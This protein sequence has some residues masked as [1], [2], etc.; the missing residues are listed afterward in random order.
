MFFD[1]YEIH[2]QAFVNLINAIGI[3]FDPHLHK[4]WYNIEIQ[5][6]LCWVGPFRICLAQKTSASG[7][8]MLTVKRWYL[9]VLLRPTGPVKSLRMRV[10]CLFPQQLMEVLSRPGAPVCV[11]VIRYG[12]ALSR[13]KRTVCV[14]CPSWY[15][16]PWIHLWIH[17][18]T[19]YPGMFPALLAPQALMVA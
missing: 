8:N 11:A 7:P 12:L 10:P 6:R 5:P 4:I 15:V 1:R 9:L 18:F 16:N 14:Y 13:E 3:I 19:F 17:G 2:I